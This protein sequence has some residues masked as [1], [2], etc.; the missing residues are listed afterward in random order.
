VSTKETIDLKEKQINGLR[1]GI[2]KLE[3]EIQVLKDQQLTELEYRNLIREQEIETLKFNQLKEYNNVQL[4]AK[5]LA[6][7]QEKI[8]I[9][10]RYLI[11]QEKYHTLLSENKG[12]VNN[13]M[14]LKTENKQL[15]DEMH[16]K[17]EK[18][19]DKEKKQL[20]HVKTE[21]EN[22]ELK[23]KLTK[24]KEK[25]HMLENK[26]QE[27]VNNKRNERVPG[28]LVSRKEDKDSG[29]IRPQTEI[30]IN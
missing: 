29:D 12:L 21:Q 13:I 22:K 1:E 11:E 24:E 8:I 18:D 9:K 19:K 15:K 17:K 26:Y 16:E 6:W 20:G 25:Y 5:M 7:E 30:R 3:Q 27:V 10:A 14:T 2:E 23:I 4:E 28:A